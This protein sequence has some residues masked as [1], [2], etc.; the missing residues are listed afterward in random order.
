MKPQFWVFI[1]SV[2]WFW[3]LYTDILQTWGVSVNIYVYIICTYTYILPYVLICIH[4]LCI[5]IFSI[6][7]SLG[8]FLASTSSGIGLCG[9]F[10]LC[11]CSYRREFS[12]FG[13]NGDTAEARLEPH[14]LS[15]F[16]LAALL[17]S[18]NACVF[19]T[20]FISMFNK[21]FKF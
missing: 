18:C 17:E 20:T 1:S 10:E 2:R 3:G 9:R 8:F 21:H 6:P 13:T 7:P 12:C 19:L 16:R 5:R 11:P 15:G 14:V 4:I